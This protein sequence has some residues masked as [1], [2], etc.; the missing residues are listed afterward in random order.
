MNLRITDHPAAPYARTRRVGFTFE[1]R[2]LHGYEGEPLATALH[3]AGVRV[4]SRSF[5]YHRPRGI[6]LTCGAPSCPNCQLAVDGQY[7]VPGCATPL[8]GGESVRRERA[9]PSADHDLFGLIDRFSAFVPA[10]FQFRLFRRSPRLAHLAERVMGLVAGGAREVTPDAI[11]RAVRPGLGGRR[12]ALAVVGAGVAGLAAAL[13]AADAGLEVVLV[14][15]GDE[16]G[17]T[18]RAETAPVRIPDGGEAPGFALAAELA[19]RA[20]AHPS[21]EVLTGSTALGWYEGGVLPVHTPAGVLTLRPDRLL[22]ATGD[23]GQPLLFPG[24][25]R[26]GIMLAGAVQRLVNVDHVRPGR[27]AVVVTSDAYGYAVAAQLRAVGVEIAALVDPR[28]AERARADA[29][30]SFPSGVAASGVPHLTG[31]LVGEALGRRRV[32]GLVVR[33]AG[34]GR[35]VR[36]ACDVV[37][38]SAGR[39]PADELLLQRLYHGDVT[40]D[41]GHGPGTG[42]ALPDGVAVAGGAAGITDPAEALATGA[43]EGARLARWSPGN[44]AARETRPGAQPEAPAEISKHPLSPGQAGRPSSSGGTSE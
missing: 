8:R 11:A 33:P 2:T 30:A 39:R 25:D 5:K 36:L 14:D 41:T 44:P 38:V 35:A 37:V 24:N 16:P 31:H 26:P 19:A 9:W 7:G 34:G 13:S 27:R 10:G 21:I 15:Q 22:V 23:Y 12:A 4:L 6:G 3:A 28:P 20:A 18:L 42:A 40:L 29:E 43:E 1:G 17:G 32:T